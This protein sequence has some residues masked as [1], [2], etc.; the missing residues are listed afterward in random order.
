MHF[1]R[2]TFSNKLFSAINVFGLATGI[3]AF[4]L[5]V[6]HAHFE[7][8]YDNFIPDN[9]RIHRVEISY[10]D[11][12]SS[13]VVSSAG[14][15]SAKPVFIDEFPGKIEA[16]TRFMP[17]ESRTL[18]TGENQFIDHVYLIDSDFFK[19]F[20]LEFI[21]GDPETAVK[22]LNSVILTE[23]MAI[24]YFGLEPA[25]G[26]DLSLDFRKTEV[27]VTGVIRDFPENSHLP[28]QIMLNVHHD[29]FSFMERLGSRWDINIFY[30][31]IKFH[32]EVQLGQVKARFPE[33]I[34][35]YLGPFF[36][37]QV[38]GMPITD[39]G[40]L[41]LVPLTDIH[42]E[43]AS[44]GSLKPHSDRDSIDALLGIAF[45]ILIV[46]V[47]NFINLSTS[48]ATK[49]AREVSMRKV[50]GASRRRLVIQ[51][52]GES[53]AT[54]MIAMIFATEILVLSMPKFSNMFDIGFTPLNHSDP[55]FFV[56]AL[57][58][59]LLV[60]FLSGFY[61]SL[62]LSSYR[63]AQ[64]VGSG[65]SES[66]GTM[67]LR[68]AMT[69][70][71]FTA[72]I[73]LI[74]GTVVI[75]QQTNF[76]RSTDLGFEK[77][78]VI[79]LRGMLRPGVLENVEGLKQQ[80]LALPEVTTIG[81]ADS[82]PGD[83]F[84]ANTYLRRPSFGPNEQVLIGNRPI[85]HS[86]LDA[87][88]V[89]PL[90]GRLFS[91]DFTAD[92]MINRIDDRPGNLTGNI[93]VNVS[94]LKLLGFESPAAAIGE[95]LVYGSDWS[96]S[97]TIIGVVPDMKYRSVRFESRPGFY[98]MDGNSFD[99]Y[100]V[101]HTGGNEKSLVTKIEEIWQRTNPQAPA[102]LDFMDENISRLYGSEERSAK[103]FLTFAFLT[104]L[105]SS[106]GLFGLAAFAAERRT[107]E[108]GLRKVFGATV[109]KIVL[110]LSLQSTRPVLWA[111]LIA[112]PLAWVFMT[113]WLLGFEY[114]INLSVVPFLGA[115]VMALFIALITVS[116]HAFMVARKNPIN[117]LRRE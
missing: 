33:L 59:F 80:L 25:L 68:S 53:Y 100:V 40:T 51:F 109:R 13:K 105:I 76:A 91:Q 22:D 35:R 75:F 30:T 111:N 41:R 38:L 47:A 88:G 62:V 107:R 63:P 32:P 101:K 71:Q 78:N 67:R 37:K 104:I 85:D 112:W 79:L 18:S 15:V 86:F 3:A 24:K 74:I 57:G 108:I 8:S 29:S 113:D 99:S 98:Y 43:P 87:L 56:A 66:R 64:I 115:G 6:L 97:G 39:Y 103:L 110:V 50:L 44:L 26:K 45:I 52:L 55:I 21:E 96:N 36:D 28:L 10:D 2:N 92:L 23:S 14:P 4:S 83:D 69:L 116:S 7:M 49:R 93:I 117:A 27:K 61:P 81:A 11:L 77:E 46:A 34:E 95:Q 70:M 9:E 102:I 42:F 16:A 58:L 20:N 31:Y 60:G 5:I 19:V 89:E 12:K 106:L 54:T 73:F 84:E 72:S 114:R 1:F 90:S 94:A 65:R 48:Q 82:I 17:L